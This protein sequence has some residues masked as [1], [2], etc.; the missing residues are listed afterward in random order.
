MTILQAEL[1]FYKSKVISSDN[2]NGG[3]MSAVE[4]ISGVVNN[5]WP[6]MLKA[7]RDAGSAAY[8]TAGALFRKLFA[9]VSNDADETFLAADLWNDIE[10]LGGDWIAMFPGTQR[11][12]QATFGSYSGKIYGCCNLNADITAGGSTF[13]L[14]LPHADAAGFFSA[15][16][17]IRLTDM[18]DPESV[19]GNE[20][21]LTVSGAPTLVGLVLTVVVAETIANS[22]TVAGGGR[23][24]SLYSPGD[25]KTSFDNWVETSAGTGTY[26]EGSFP[27]VLD[28]IGTV[29]ETWTLTFTDATN[30][31]VVGDSL[32]TIGSG[33]TG[34][35]FAPSNGDFSKPYC[36]LE[37]G[38]WANTW[39]AGDTIVFQTHPAAAPFILKRVHAA[40]I[41]SQA[42]N[43]NTTVYSGE[44]A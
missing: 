41:G 3:R 11:D 44:S 30:F 36:T 10:T 12:T 32:G 23:A 16:D 5:V 27:P 19:T 21:L 14:L 2:V 28:N 39:A 7:E 29:D 43:K 33:T 6:H 15:S 22:Y 25:V 8:Y 42:G 1:E 34:V 9:K 31:T 4:A 38:G 20:E 40:G 24:M 17:N 37:S 35:D 13:D 26:D 18:V